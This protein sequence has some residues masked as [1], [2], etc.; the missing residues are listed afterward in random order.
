MLIVK[1]SGRSQVPFHG[2]DDEDVAM[3]ITR[4]WDLKP[5]VTWLDWAEGH[6]TNHS[7]WR[8]WGS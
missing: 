8:S 6:G 7:A 4:G 3:V 2:L 1:D 5:N